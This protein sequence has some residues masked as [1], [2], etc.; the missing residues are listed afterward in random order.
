MHFI[1]HPQNDM[2]LEGCTC[3]WG[4]KLLLSF[5]HTAHVPSFTLQRMSPF[6]NFKPFGPKFVACPTCCNQQ[7]CI[8]LFSCFVGQ[9][10]VETTKILCPTS[11]ASL[12]SCLT[13]LWLGVIEQHSKIVFLNKLPCHACIHCHYKACIVLFKIFYTFLV[14]TAETPLCPWISQLLHPVP[15]FLWGGTVWNILFRL[16]KILMILHRPSYSVFDPSNR[17]WLFSM[18]STFITCINW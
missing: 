14:C 12:F 15:N 10:T 7:C 2:M 17:F 11:S 3:W 16:S 9:K 6:F 8:C 5:R 13:V 18:R 4:G 1:L